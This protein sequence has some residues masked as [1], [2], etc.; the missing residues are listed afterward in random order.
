MEYLVD[1]KQSYKLENKEDKEILIPVVWLGFAISGAYAIQGCDFAKV[2][3]VIILLTMLI[4]IITLLSK[5]MEILLEL[6]EEY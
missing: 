3:F 2:V 5:A 6:V 4:C 1:N